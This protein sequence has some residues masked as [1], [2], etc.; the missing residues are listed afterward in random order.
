MVYIMDMGMATEHTDVPPEDH[1][2]KSQ[3]AQAEDPDP[4]KLMGTELFASVNGHI[5][6]RES[7]SSPPSPNIL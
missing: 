5:G 1:V 4:D 3:R 7:P 2:V 6:R